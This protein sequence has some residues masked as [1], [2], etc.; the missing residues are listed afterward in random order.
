MRR[1][2]RRCRAALPGK[3][4]RQLAPMGNLFT[5]LWHAGSP[6]VQS[7]TSL[8]FPIDCAMVAAAPALPA[9]YFVSASRIADRRMILAEYR[10]ADLLTLVNSKLMEIKIQ[11]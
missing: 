1:F 3:I 7:S 8:E 6:L 9:G 2:C 5:L 4:N 11:Y 10:L